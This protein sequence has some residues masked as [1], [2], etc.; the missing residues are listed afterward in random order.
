M[1]NFRPFKCVTA[2][3]YAFLALIGGSTL[4]FGQSE[5]EKRFENEA[6][7]VEKALP[8]AELGAAN[9]DDGG[10]PASIISDGALGL[11]RNNDYWKPTPD[12]ALPMEYEQLDA[13]TAR[14]RFNANSI[15]KLRKPMNEIRI[16]SEEGSQA[17][18]YLA[19]HYIVKEPVLKIVAAGI[20]PPRPDR[21]P[22][23][24]KHRP[25]YYEQP[26]LERCGRG[27]GPAQNAISAGQFCVNTFFL[28]YH[29]CKTRP[30]CLVTSGGDCL[31]C[32]PYPDDCNPLPLNYRGLAIEAA[33]FAGFSFLLL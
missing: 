33:T 19:A 12:P 15:Q 11:K 21:Y 8:E 17:P 27:C 3:L 1:L 18:Q 31:S 26:Q 32:Q 22:I 13:E 25:L 6:Q 4:V 5:P 10:P 23:H 28:P 14:D 16:V 2:S 24:F 7:V 29:M 30:A 20:S 9:D